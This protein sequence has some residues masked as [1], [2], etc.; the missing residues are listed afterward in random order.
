MREKETISQ[1]IEKQKQDVDCARSMITQSK[2]GDA[3]FL[4]RI[5]IKCQ[6]IEQT[7]K[8][9]K[10]KSRATYQTLAEIEQNMM[11]E[12]SAVEDKFETWIIED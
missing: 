11:A 2:A 10:L 3:S 7:L 12:I 9:F 1:F 6:M 5:Q 4:D 8:N